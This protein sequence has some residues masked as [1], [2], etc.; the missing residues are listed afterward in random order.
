MSV[1]REMLQNLFSRPF[2]IRYPAEK[3]PVPACFRGKV[4][5]D[6]DR[7]IGCSKCAL[8][9]PAQVITMVDAP[10]EVEF[11]GKTLAR[12]KRPQ[13]KVFKCI[14]CGICERHCPA[15]AI[16]LK[17]ELS[18]TGTDREIVVT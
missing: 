2:T 9:C 12:K 4:C 5:I 17:P 6:D 3:V 15:G 1:I 13:V 14:R 11:R 7:C 16:T 18:V 8:V 10:R